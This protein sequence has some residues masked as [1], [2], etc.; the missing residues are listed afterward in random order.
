MQRHRIS[1]RPGDVGHRGGIVEIAT[2]GGVGQKE[3]MA[4]QVDQYLDV[5]CREAHAGRDLADDLH[6]H[7][8]VVTRKAFADVVQQ[9]ADQQQIWSL[10]RVGNSEATAAASNR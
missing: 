4:H 1:R 6:A 3:V 2:R 5:G 9:G 8:R 7:R 10:D